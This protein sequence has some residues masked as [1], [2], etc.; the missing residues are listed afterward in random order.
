MHVYITGMV[1]N[2]I[3][4]IMPVVV[5]DHEFNCN[6]ASTLKETEIHSMDQTKYYYMQQ[7]RLISDNK[8]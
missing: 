4:M 8:I 2:I 5:N 1:D 3:F 7:I 6:L